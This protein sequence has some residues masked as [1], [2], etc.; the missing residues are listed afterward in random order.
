MKAIKV[1]G[2]NVRDFKSLDSARAKKNEGTREE[3][4]ARKV[5]EATINEL[6]QKNDSVSFMFNGKPVATWTSNPR[7]D[8]DRTKLQTEFPEAYKACYIQGQVWT[9]D[10]L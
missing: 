2:D 7:F 1:N 10:V 3:K 6:N 5:L 4:N 8:L 9:L